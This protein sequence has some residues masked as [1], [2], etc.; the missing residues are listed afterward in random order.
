VSGDPVH[1]NQ[2]GAPVQRGGHRTILG[3]VLALAAVL[4]GLAA[5]RTAVGEATSDL[6]PGDVQVISKGDTV[7]LRAAAVKGKY[8]V[9]DFYADWCPPCRQ[10]DVGLRRLAAEHRD[11]AI[12]KID[13][14]D[15]TTPVVKQHGV[16]GL[17]HM[18]VYD[19]EGRRL[20]EGDDVYPLLSRLFGADL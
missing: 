8:T 6:P 14:I 18:V 17:P 13:I 5:W 15:W 4:I 16:E 3:L 11:V 2:R 20:A 10:L 12:R 19:P 9:Y 1:D 7:D